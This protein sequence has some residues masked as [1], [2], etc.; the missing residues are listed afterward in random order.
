ME[1]VVCLELRSTFRTDSLWIPLKMVFNAPEAVT[2]S[3]RQSD[4]LCED[5]ETNRT[6]QVISYKPHDVFIRRHH[7]RR[8]L[9]NALLRIE[10]ESSRS[11][12][13][14]HIRS[15]PWSEELNYTWLVF[16]LRTVNVDGLEDTGLVYS[17]SEL[18]M[19]SLIKWLIE[20]VGRETALD[21]R[22]PYR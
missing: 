9:R 6:F 20:N 21:L 16:P 14:D 1:S 15:P 11:D 2:V 8:S 7:H 18:K 17:S 10:N 12:D 22:R 4:R 19:R 5:L 13:A 3:A